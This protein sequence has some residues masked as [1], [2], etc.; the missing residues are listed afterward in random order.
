MSLEMTTDR[1]I[2]ELNRELNAIINS[3]SDGLFV[4]RADGTVIRINPASERMHHVRAEEML[5]KNI[6]TLVEE[7]FVDRSAALEAIRS[8]KQV[9][10][11]QNHRGRKLMSTGTPVFDE[12]GALVLVVVTV[13]DVTEIDQLQRSIEEE[14]ARSSQFREQMLAAQQFELEE[15][16]IIARSPVMV[17]VLKQAVRAGGADSTVLILGESGVGKGVV[18]DLIHSHSK[19]AQGPMI[20]INCGAI[21]ETLIESELFGYEKGAF[22]G[23]QTA[24][25]GYFELA[26]G[27]TLFLD[28]IAELPLGSQVKLLRFLE[29][30]RITR[31]GATTA[32]AIN[33]RVLAATHR[34]LEK[35]VASERFRLDLYYRLNVIPL[36]V[37]PLRER[38]DCLLPLLRHYIGYFGRRGDLTRRLGRAAV[39]SL[40]AYDYPGNVRE[41]MNLCERLVVM[42]ETEV[43]GETDLPRMIRPTQSTAAAN[44]PLWQNGQTL[45]E[46]LASVERRVLTEMSACCANQTEV[47]ARLGINQSTVARKL[48]KHHSH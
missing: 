43:I 4:C 26:D 16:Q 39:D 29:D 37:P 38:H 46:I 2:E 18:A 17:Q 11:L 6:F 13:R 5:G 41:L 45:A 31:L 19:R 15:R 14:E 35:M 23:A 21:P 30:G 27:G 20:R 9:S 1:T 24:K 28:E 36:T 42:S 7:G 25:P 22:T 12:A 32:S 8:R 10:V 40:L 48:K 34:D 47:A 3:S 33:V 44:D